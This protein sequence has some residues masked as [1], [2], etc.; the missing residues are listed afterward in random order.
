MSNGCAFFLYLLIFF[1]CLA[2]GIWAPVYYWDWSLWLSIPCAIISS[3]LLTIIVSFAIWPIIGMMASIVGL[4]G[5]DE[6]SPVK[7][8]GE[9]YA[10][11]VKSGEESDKK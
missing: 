7:T 6:A 10:I 5:D 11:D 3:P 2:L 8:D 1:C 9:R 4:D